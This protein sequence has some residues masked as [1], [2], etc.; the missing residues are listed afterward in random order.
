MPMSLTITS[1]RRD[2]TSSSASS[3]DSAVKTSAAASPSTVA[4]SARASGS[5]STTST[6]TPASER[7]GLTTMG[8]RLTA[9]GSRVGKDSS[10]VERTGNSTVNVA[11]RSA[12]ALSARTLPP[13]SSTNCLTIDKPKPR[14]PWRRVVDESA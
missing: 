5:S 8:A 14:P 9:C 13:C 3:T 7:S 6:T 2:F 12:P 4:T 10:L 11:P 1:K